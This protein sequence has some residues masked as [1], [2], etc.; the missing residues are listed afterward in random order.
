MRLLPIITSIALLIASCSVYDSN[1]SE[2]GEEATK[3][4]AQS[5]KVTNFIWKVIWFFYL[6]ANTY[7]LVHYR[8]LIVYVNVT[9]K[10]I[11]VIGII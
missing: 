8:Y 7:K 11:W 5:N 4:V 9:N 10:W 6:N 2:E 3:K 1:I